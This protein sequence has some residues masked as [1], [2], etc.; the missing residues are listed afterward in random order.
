MVASWCCCKH[1]L[2]Y[3]IFDLDTFDR[4][5]SVS[6]VQG[7]QLHP[8]IFEEDLHCTHQ[9]SELLLN[10]G[11][12]CEYQKICTPQF[13]SIAE[14]LPREIYYWIFFSKQNEKAYPWY[15]CLNYLNKDGTIAERLESW[16]IFSFWKNLKCLEIT[17]G[18]YTVPASLIASLNPPQISCFN[19]FLSD[20]PRIP[21]DIL[22]S[23]RISSKNIIFEL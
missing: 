19:T 20:I 1:L 17:I 7:V 15:Q 23:P 21:Q 22:R 6:G 9:F 18:M 14:P 4:K 11:H 5:G 16:Q 3:S 8:S 13:E 12:I 10:Y 2:D